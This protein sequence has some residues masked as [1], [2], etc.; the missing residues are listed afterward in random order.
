MNNLALA[1]V[2]PLLVA[3]AF[4]ALLG[5]SAARGRSEFVSGE[6]P[7]L[8]ALLKRRHPVVNAVS[9]VGA[10][11]IVL[12]VVP[13]VSF[14]LFGVEDL[15]AFGLSFALPLCVLAVAFLVAERVWGRIA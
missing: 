9:A 15:A 13:K 3:A 5:L 12:Y 10:W 1:L 2:P 4:G 11:A 8:D 14:V 6:W 7:V